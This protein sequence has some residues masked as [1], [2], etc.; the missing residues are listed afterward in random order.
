MLLAATLARTQENPVGPLYGQILARQKRH[1]SRAYLSGQKKNKL[2]KIH[3]VF[4]SVLRG[5]V[6][7]IPDALELEKQCKKNAQKSS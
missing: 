2:N 5:R 1:P 6:Q 4:I 3:S 7:L